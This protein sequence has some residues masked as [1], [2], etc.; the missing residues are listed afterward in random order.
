MVNSSN[1]YISGGNWPGSLVPMEVTHEEKY[2]QVQ[3]S[4]I[5]VVLKK[6]GCSKKEQPLTIL[7]NDLPDNTKF[8]SNYFTTHLNKY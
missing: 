8:L 3:L 7:K 6:S 1:P 2:K 4:G 5:P